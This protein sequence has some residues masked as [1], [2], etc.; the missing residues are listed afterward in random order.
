MASLDSALVDMVH[1]VEDGSVS[2][3]ALLAQATTRIHRLDPQVHAWVAL[4]PAAEDSAAEPRP[5]PLRGVPVGVKDII[6]LMGL[7]TRCGSTIT[8]PDPVTAN[9]ACIDLVRSLGAI[10]VGKTVT[11]EF[12]YFKPGPTNNPA[13]PGHTP[14][15]SSSGSAAA[16][17]AGMV[18][19]ALGSQTAGSL[20]R[21]AAFCGV[22]GMV[23]AR[24]AIDLTGVTGLSP[25][26]D[27][28]GLLARTVADVA[29]AHQALTGVGSQSL[30]RRVLMWRGS[31]LDL[32]SPAMR[33]AVASAEWRLTSELAGVSPLGWDDHVQTLAADHAT[34]MGYEA[35]RERP[36]L[37]KR[38]D[39]LSA[40]LVELLRGGQ[41]ISDDDYQAA[42]IR[43]DRS[44]SELRALLAGGGVIVGPAALGPAPA[45]L[46]AT[47]S[48]ILSRPWQLLGLPVVTV[49]GVRSGDGRPLGLQV[50]G[51]PG[52]EGQVLALAERLEQL[53]A[54]TRTTS[55]D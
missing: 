44:M 9:A 42:L 51:L 3:S 20:T 47:G 19:L 27:S 55:N 23:L 41:R 34:V 17:A 18:P 32:I 53:L 39:E 45:G 46:S 5:G 21:P 30:P 38:A 48:P 1:A 22:A 29:Y 37:L 52:A 36:E 12:A 50:V 11:T 25:S 33:E 14:G 54:G 15:G 31:E 49:P 40:P 35:C 4:D 2:A 26:L 13:A 8:S 10:P 43:R 24:G 28:L 16:V 7:P 6:D